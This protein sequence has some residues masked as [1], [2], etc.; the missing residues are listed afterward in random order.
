M[1]KWNDFTI[2]EPANVEA[3][4]KKRAATIVEARSQAIKDAPKPKLWSAKKTMRLMLEAVE[5]GDLPFYSQDLAFDKRKLL[6]KKLKKAGWKLERENVFGENRPFNPKLR[7]SAWPARRFCRI[8]VSPCATYEACM[9]SIESDPPI[10]RLS[11]AS[12]KEP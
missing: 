6:H 1:T 3:W 11:V 2:H 9:L 8:Y 12:L 4:A 5:E 10:T 7:S